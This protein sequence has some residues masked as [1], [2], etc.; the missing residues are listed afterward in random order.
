VDAVAC[1]SRDKGNS[2]DKGQGAR[3]KVGAANIA[4]WV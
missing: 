2:R 4:R 1:F 3:D